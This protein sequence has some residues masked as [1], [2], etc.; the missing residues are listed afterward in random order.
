MAIHDIASL[1]MMRFCFRIACRSTGRVLLGLI[2]FWLAF[3]GSAW[4][5]VQ[6]SSVVN[7][8]S[9][10]SGNPIAPGTAVSIFGRGL[11][12]GTAVATSFPLPKVL[13]QTVVTVNGVAAPLYFVSPQQ[14]NL[15]LPY[16][17]NGSS[18]SVVVKVGAVVSDAIAVTLASVTP[19]IFSLLASGNGPAALIHLDGKIVSR[20]APLQPGE[21]VSLYLTGLGE[22]VPSVESGAA[23][24]GPPGLAIVRTPVR[25]LFDG[26][27]GRV[28]FTGLAP[29]FAGLYQINVTAPS[30][31]VN[32]Y[33]IIRV[34]AGGNVSNAVSAGGPGLFDVTP[35]SSPAAAD[36]LVVVRGRNF[37]KNTE[38]EV[39]GERLAGRFTAGDLDEFRTT[40]PARLLSSPG[41]VAITVLNT[42]G[43]IVNRS[44]SLDY[45][46]TPME[47]PVTSPYVYVID[48]LR[49]VEFADALP[50]TAVRS[51]SVAAARNEY[52]SFQ[53]IIKGA[54]TGWQGVSAALKAPLASPLGA[55]IPV[56]NVRFYRA[57]YLTVDKASN[58]G[59]GGA[60]AGTYP[61]S[62][63]PFLNPFTGQPLTGGQ[64]GSA[65]FDVAAARNQTIY[66][67]LFAP[68]GTPAGVYTG[69]ISV[70]RYGNIKLADVPVSVTV[71][72]FDLPTA[73][74]LH[75]AIQANDSDYAIGPAAYYGY[76]TGSAQ[77]L[78]VATAM[79]EQL[80]AHRLMPENPHYIGFTV[81]SDGSI[82]DPGNML[83]TYLL[84]PEC[85]DYRLPFSATYPFTR[86]LDTNRTKAIAYLRNAYA[87]LAARNL[88]G[89][90][91]LRQYDEP[92]TTAQFQSARD[93]ADLIH[94]ANP[95]Y[96]VAITG[97]FSQSGFPAYLYGHLNIY[98]M[99]LWNYDPTAA[100][101]R[102]A[103]KDDVW[104]YTALVQNSGNPSPFWQIDFPLLNY[105]VV[106]W[107][108]YRYGLTGLQHWTAAYW[109]E[110]RAR[111]QSPWTNPCS[112]LA[113]GLCFNGEG[114]LF[115][116]GKEVN[117]VVPAGAYGNTS[118]AAV[119]GPIA[120]LRL[121]ALRDG[122]EDYE[123][124][125]LAARKNPNATMEAA[126]QVACAGNRNLGDAV[127]N[128][129]HAWNKDPDNLPKTR[130][131]LA[132]II[133]AG[134]YPQAQSAP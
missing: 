130:A 87:W 66:V 92:Q 20:D 50:A 81:R 32:P 85:G 57:G 93:F 62:L 90:V 64:Y 40:I 105:R 53:I 71:W 104:S 60:K 1:P 108:Q 134:Q 102:Q 38:L 111:G 16:G 65:P 82:S 99:G 48:S 23:A 46:V 80:I 11:A 129:F 30:V 58:A 116:P 14:V 15:Q 37:S 56:E 67:E 26:V 94:E 119:Y 120:S 91:W 76:T 45:T 75:S 98:I 33:P 61:D 118:T 9:Y 133:T 95:N 42:S 131:A 132:L 69:S 122:M 113:S 126:L 110:L 13:G 125:V 107:I 124:L 35:P 4:A 21:T 68:L 34:E 84:R 103:N 8:A 106:P 36:V 43:S 128:C 7:A 117:Y 55:S 29:Y 17:L 72:N 109:N 73:P 31:L 100:A 83:E 24:P 79:N 115:Y 114:M 27:E 59:Q 70:T 54:Q 44:N 49:R 47:P 10:A 39:G 112:M 5:Q 3:A 63:I 18:A 74:S 96:K 19:G 2:L 52:E 89:K 22:V 77:H 41:R 127:T 6:V 86:P 123:L 101:Q 28:G 25:V 51:A 88:L 97:D 78:S 12:T 121:K